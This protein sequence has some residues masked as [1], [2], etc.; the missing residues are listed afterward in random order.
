VASSR[1]CRSIFDTSNLMYLSRKSKFAFCE[2]GT[3]TVRHACQCCG[4][5]KTRNYLTEQSL[6]IFHI[7]TET[8]TNKSINEQCKALTAARKKRVPCH[9]ITL[10]LRS[11]FTLR[12]SGSADPFLSRDSKTLMTISPTQMI[13]EVNIFISQPTSKHGLLGVKNNCAPVDRAARV[14]QWLRGTRSALDP[15]LV[16]GLRHRRNISADAWR[17]M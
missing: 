2:D 17:W 1:S 14:E 12:A 7:H 13:Q 3:L 6:N 5:T 16:E 11:L 10:D 9:Q 4:S 8:A 15:C